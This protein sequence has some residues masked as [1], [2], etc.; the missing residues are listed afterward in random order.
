[1]VVIYVRKFVPA[2][3]DSAF[4]EIAVLTIIDLHVMKGECRWITIY[5]L[6]NI[7]VV[8]VCCLRNYWLNFNLTRLLI[9]YVKRAVHDSML[10]RVARSSANTSEPVTAKP[11][12]A[13]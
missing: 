3:L 6:H 2:Y 11:E 12:V 8:P 5:I 13:P 7:S 9:P 10:F 4:F 1:L